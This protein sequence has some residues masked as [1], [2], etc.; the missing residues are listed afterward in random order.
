IAQSGSAFRGATKANATKAAE[1]FLARIGLKPNQLD[2]V[3]RMDWRQLREAFEK[4]PGIQ[5]LAGGPVT[6]GRSM[7]RDQW[8]P[9][10]PEVSATVPFMQGSVETE[11]AWTEP[12]P[13]L[14]MPEEEMLTRV[15][16]IVRN[17]DAKA[18]EMVAMYRRT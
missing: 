1:E 12:V 4:R 18:K 15:K 11:D 3:Q 7:P 2:E 10:A 16:R 13:A 5:N 8:Y 6:D 9:D 17:D 14:E